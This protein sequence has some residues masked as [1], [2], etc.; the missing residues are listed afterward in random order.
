MFGRFRPDLDTSRSETNSAHVEAAWSPSRPARRRGPLCRQRLARAR[1]RGDP[2]VGALQGLGTRAGRA[3]LPRGFLQRAG[4]AIRG[5]VVAQCGAAPSARARRSER[6]R[7][8]RHVDACSGSAGVHRQWVSHVPAPSG[9]PAVCAP[10]AGRS[11]TRRHPRTRAAGSG[12]TRVLARAGSVAGV[13]RGGVGSSA[14]RSVG[15]GRGL[16]C[17][18]C[19]S[20]IRH[21][22]NATPLGCAHIARARPR[23][24]R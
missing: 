18:T 7:P 11:R 23:R 3:G 10:W 15:R 5:L 22:S 13:R 16:C 8:E 24:A 2:C 20:R 17:T 6:R 9:V 21:C 4:R 19:S 12:S 1:A 14:G